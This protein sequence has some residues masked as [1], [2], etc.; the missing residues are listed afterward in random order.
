[1]KKLIVMLLVLVTLGSGEVAYG[2]DPTP[3]PALPPVRVPGWGEATVHTLC[4]EVEQSYPDIEGEFSQPIAETARRILTGVGLQVVDKGAS[5]EATLTITLTGQASVAQEPS[6]HFYSIAEFSGN[7]TLTVPERAPLILPLSG[8]H[9]A[10]LPGV[11]YC[12]GEPTE[13]P[14]EKAWPEALLDGLAYLWGPQVS[15]QVLGDEDENMR[16]AAA[17]T[18]GS[19]GPEEGVIPALIQALGD[20]DEEVRTA[21]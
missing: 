12:P 21:A 16:R 2:A 7:V 3:M 17:W 13:A 10:S 18:L 20:E 9:S 14:F 1:M 19:I 15:I 5:C 4:L 6:G 11:S 8:S